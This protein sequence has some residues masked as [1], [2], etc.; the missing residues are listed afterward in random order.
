[1]NS[2]I[3]TT[4]TVSLFGFR[5]VGKF[6][7]TKRHNLFLIDRCGGPNNFETDGAQEDEILSG[8]TSY[9]NSIK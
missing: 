4:G 5:A 3:V 2:V 9:N 7:P 6:E 1:M 8:L